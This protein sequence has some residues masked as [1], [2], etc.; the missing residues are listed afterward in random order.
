MRKRFEYFRVEWIAI[1]A[2]TVAI[3]A[4]IAM[5]AVTILTSTPTA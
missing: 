4:T 3:V 2:L 5:I 1:E